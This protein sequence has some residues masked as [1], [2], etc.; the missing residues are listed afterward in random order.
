LLVEHRNLCKHLSTEVFTNVKKT[1]SNIQNRTMDLPK[2]N[3][4]QIYA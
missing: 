1:S 2:I 4:L 3:Y